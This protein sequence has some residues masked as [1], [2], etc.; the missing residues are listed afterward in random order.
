MSLDITLLRDEPTE[1]FEGNITHNLNKM[2][3]AVG[4]YK[5][6]WRPEEVGI[7][8][9]KDLIEPLKMGIYKMRKE[10]EKYKAFNPYNGWGSYDNLLTLMEQYL[11]AC[12]AYPDAIVKVWR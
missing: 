12:Q 11:I 4:V 3:D 2:A 9:G 7:E 5:Q 10:P 1:V 8:R 6:L